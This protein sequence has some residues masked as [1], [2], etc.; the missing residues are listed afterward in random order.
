MDSTKKKHAA[1]ALGCQ[2]CHVAVPGTNHP[3]QKGSIQLTKAMPDLCYDCHDA[4]KFNTKNVHKPVT[5]GTCTGC[6]NPHSSDSNNL[7]IQNM[8]NLCYNCHDAA[9]FEGANVHEPVGGGLC[10]GCHNPHGSNYKK[11]LLAPSPEV[12]FTCHD[13]T[14]FTR[15]YVHSVITLGCESCHQPHVSDNQNLITHK[16]IHE[17]CVTCHVNKADGRHVTSIPGR[18]KRIHPVKGVKDPTVPWTKKIPDPHMPGKE[19]EVPDP[20]KQG[21]ELSCVSCHLPHSS[22]YRKLFPVGNI[23]AKC[24]KFY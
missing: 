9:K 6:H 20:D 2:S 15:K 10:T 4:A 16:S 24:H 23:C 22:D 3:T 17:L 5:T 8:P 21:K 12:C 11:I 1:I 7:L 19:L 13:K 14:E 18:G